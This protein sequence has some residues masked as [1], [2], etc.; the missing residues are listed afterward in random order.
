MLPKIAVKP[1]LNLLIPALL[2]VITEL[3]YLP[4]L[5]YPFEFDDIPNILKFYK[6]RS[7]T[8]SEL[9]FS[10][11]R[12]IS[13]WL[14]TLCY[15]IAGFNP[16]IYRQL[17][18]LIHIS[19]G[20]LLYYLFYRLLARFGANNFYHKYRLIIASLATTLFLLHPVQTQT[21]TYVIQ[22]QLE[23]LATLL[24]LVIANLFV[25]VRTTTQ[26][27]TK[28][29][30]TI[31][32]F[33]AA[34]LATGTKEIVI[35]T[36]LLLL[37]IDWWFLAQG[38]R[39]EIA[40]QW[41]LYVGLSTLL[42]IA[43]G[44]LLKPAFFKNILTFNTATT[45]TLGNP[46]TSQP[47]AIIRPWNY[48]ISEF[49][50]ILHYLWI[51]ICPMGLSFEYDWKLVDSFWDPAS[52]LPF[53]ALVTLLAGL[54]WRWRTNKLAVTVFSLLWFLVCILPRSS[55]IPSSELIND[56]KTYLAS[57]GIMLLL[58]IALTKV[59]VWLLTRY[60]RTWKPKLPVP[61]LAFVS[62][63]LLLIGSLGYATYQRNLVSADPVSYWAD[64]VLKGPDKARSHN[65][66]GI[67]LT[68]AH[69]FH[70]AI[71]EF[72]IALQLAGEPTSA[73]RFYWDPYNNL[74]NVYSLTGNVPAA[75]E[76][77]ERGLKFN[78]NVAEPY[79]NL[80]MFYLNSKKFDQAAANFKQAL[81]LKPYHGKA[82]F[83]LA[84][85]Y[86]IQQDL[87]AACA[88][89]EQACFNSD[90]D[91]E[92]TALVTALELYARTCLMRQDPQTAARAFERLL[93]FKPQDPQLLFNLAGTYAAQKQYPAAIKLYQRLV[94]LDPENIRL[95]ANLSELYRLNEQLEVALSTIERALK[96]EPKQPNLLFQ[97]IRCLK[98]LKQLDQAQA[99]VDMMRRESEYPATLK[100]AAQ[101][102]LK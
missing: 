44:Y 36:P 81:K 102:L 10:G 4:S 84:K 22:G 42:L 82:H 59:L 54:I 20:L 97:Q 80:G 31:A 2:A 58:G 26:P 34:L 5:T 48:L 28:I 88:A 77:L 67:A 71:R 43:Y 52:L 91:T 29:I 62:L 60:D 70:E 78:P 35:I 19:A 93:A 53:L 89:L 65:N 87:A 75:I 16:V 33:S 90:L 76:L 86:L 9:F 73:E 46:L 24:V 8:F 98:S 6:I 13:Y 49:R 57:A 11:S 21:V 72:K 1:R 100:Q 38:N 94:K 3:I 85:V 61:V 40:S 95:L 30:S 32:L 74:A 45:S 96:L 56:Y 37:L 64:I 15:Q 63:L 27:N 83:N 79:N 25:T 51:F 12:W 17:N 39:R 92:P 47:D 99:V 66:Y 68:R 18:V 101:E 55:C 7:A 69:R 23:G 50:V 14:N 41:G